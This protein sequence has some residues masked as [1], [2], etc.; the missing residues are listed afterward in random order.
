MNYTF[1]KTFTSC[2]IVWVI[3]SLLYALSKNITVLH[4]MVGYLAFVGETGLDIVCFILTIKL[5]SKTTSTTKN[6][7]TLFAISFFFGALSDS[8]YNIVLNI[9]NAN[10]FNPLI[11][12]IF[13]IPFALFLFFQLIAWV[14]LFQV[15]HT[16]Q[17]IC[18]KQNCYLPFAFS[19]LI[20]LLSFFLLPSWK[21]NRLSVEGFFNILDTLLEVSAFSLLVICLFSAKD[22]IITLLSSGFLIVIASDFVIRY[23]EVEQKLFPGSPLETTWVLGL[24]LFSLGLYI[25]LKTNRVDFKETFNRWNSLKA[26]TG[27]CIFTSCLM[28]LVV[29]LATN[30]IFANLDIRNFDAIPATLIF[31][32]ILSALLSRALSSHFTKPFEHLV[33]I[34]NTYKDEVVLTNNRAPQIA[35]EEFQQLESCLQDSLKTIKNKKMIDKQYVEAVLQYTESIKNPIAALEILKNDIDE[36]PEKQR[37]LLKD[38][39]SS[40]S[41]LTNQLLAKFNQTKNRIKTLP[42]ILIDDSDILRRTWACEAENI[43]IELIT[44]STPEAFQQYADQLER[45]CNIYIDLNLSEKT[46]GLELAKWAYDHGF[47]N[48]YL[49]TGEDPQNIEQ[50]SWIKAILDKSMPFP[51]K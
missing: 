30:E 33:N 24:L 47:K 34:I 6:I 28:A 32:A 16:N 15:M 19:I 2:L 8:S 21:I 37:N 5:A 10:A 36:L 17:P 23:T 27:Y 50:P 43:G 49:V 11:E 14:K 3:Y 41:T 35:I 20:I 9:L 45:D 44:F 31:F 7:F 48:L 1:I 25:F 26:Q 22:K 46:N 18:I 12:T 42:I 13:D 40:I 51:S 39:I 29:L 38:V 4:S